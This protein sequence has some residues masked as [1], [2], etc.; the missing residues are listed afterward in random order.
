MLSYQGF[1]ASYFSQTFIFN[2]ISNVPQG[3]TPGEALEADLLGLGE[4]ASAHVRLGPYSLPR[5]TNAFPVPL[6]VVRLCTFGS[7]GCQVTEIFFS[8]LWNNI[9]CFVIFR[10]YL[11]SKT[12]NPAPKGVIQYSDQQ[13]VS[14]TALCKTRNQVKARKAVKD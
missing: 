14:F 9:H 3:A 1:I 11:R 6:K 5:G 8:K 12:E 4:H 13:V 7:F 2:S 10:V